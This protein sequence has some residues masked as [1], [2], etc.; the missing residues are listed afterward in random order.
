MNLKAIILGLFFCTNS[1]ATD[2]VTCETIFS[3]SGGTPGTSMDKARINMSLSTHSTRFVSSETHQVSTNCYITIIKAKYI[4][5][6]N[7]Y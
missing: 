4:N 3:G 5:Y 6:I 2:I 1:I 7:S